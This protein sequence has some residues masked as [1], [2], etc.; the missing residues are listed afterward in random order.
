MGLTEFLAEHITSLIAHFGYISVFFLMILESMVF[1]I[2]SEAVMPFAGFLVA[3]KKFT[4][5][6]VAFFSTFGSLVGSLISY[7]IG[8]YGGKPFL[9]KYGKF[10]FLDHEEL[11]A[12]D[13]FFNKY[14]EI[15]IF[16]SRFIPIIRHLISLP[17]GLSKMNLV[18]FSF[19]TVIG[20][21][22]WNTFLAVCGFYL[23]QNWNSIMRYSHVLDIGV[24]M[25]FLVL[26]G[27]FIYKH[28][29]RKK[30]IFK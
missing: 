22:L 29:K 28:L 21:G 25:I 4:F 3:E 23:R 14:G 16:I 20:A 7:Y 27:L 8:L 18:K 17:A 1:P 24:I 13:K 11:E 30:I 19:Y 2:P 10:F 26:I 6:L 12:T 15:T 9:A 5:M